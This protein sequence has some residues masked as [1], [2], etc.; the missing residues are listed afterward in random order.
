[1][2]KKSF[3]GKLNLNE[4]LNFYADLKTGDIV[5]KKVHMKKVTDRKLLA[6]EVQV[7]NCIYSTSLSLFWQIS[8]S[9][10]VSGLLFCNYFQGL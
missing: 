6:I 8:I 2:K 4:K 10:A 3:A 9:V 5:A 1:M 7:G